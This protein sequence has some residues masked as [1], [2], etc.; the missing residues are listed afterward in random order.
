MRIQI[1]GVAFLI[2][3]ALI[4]TGAIGQ[5]SRFVEPLAD[6]EARRQAALLDIDA[7]GVERTRVGRPWPWDQQE[8]DARSRELLQALPGRQRQILRHCH[9][10]RDGFRLSSA[11]VEA[12]W[13]PLEQARR[14]NP[15]A[16][17]PLFRSIDADDGQGDF[18]LL[19]T[20]A[21]VKVR[22]DDFCEPI[23]AYMKKAL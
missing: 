17:D 8:S 4:R 21:L 18:T 14:R 23:L 13:A 9:N 16:T 7:E 20:R 1:I 22:F 3:G 12:R 6:N 11:T 15:A 5:N 2:I 10:P 19:R